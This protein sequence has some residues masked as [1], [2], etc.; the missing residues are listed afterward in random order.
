MLTTSKNI[1][2]EKFDYEKKL[3]LIKTF[4]LVKFDVHTYTWAKIWI[5]AA[6]KSIY[7]G[8]CFWNLNDKAVKLSMMTFSYPSTSYLAYDPTFHVRLN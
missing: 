7:L 3:K 1:F 8:T 6:E 4:L 2:K 5:Q